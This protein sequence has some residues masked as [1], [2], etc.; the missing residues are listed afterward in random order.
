MKKLWLWLF[1]L[2]FIVAAATASDLKPPFDLPSAKVLP[3]GVRNFT[4]KGVLIDGG[5]KFN[6]AG[7]TERLSAPLNKDITFQTLLDSKDDPIDRGSITQP[8]KT[9]GATKDTKLGQTTGELDIAATANVPVFAYGITKKLTLAIAVPVVQSSI[10][11]DAGVVHT[12]PQL[13]NDF[14]TEIE[15]KGASDKAAEFDRKIKD[16]IGSKLEEYGY[17]ELKNENKTQLG[18]I[19]LVG[20]YNFIN[21]KRHV[22]TLQ[23]DITLPTGKEAD[24]NKVV[25]I[26]GGDG[27][28]DLGLTVIHD[29]NLGNYFTISSSLGYIAQL[30]DETAKRIPEVHDSSLSPDIDYN[31]DRNLGDHLNASLA[32]KF[33][34]HGFN[35][36]SGYSILYKE[37]D[38][39]SGN[40][41]SDERYGWLEQNTRQNMHAVQIST[42]YDTISLFKQKR[43]P[44]PL[45]LSIN[46]TRLVRGKNV[47][48]D[49]LTSLNFS[50]FF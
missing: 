34:Y 10:A 4:Y 36:G 20:K 38:R 13:V 44:V 23:G 21:S 39:Y 1:S 3:P 31:I 5:H 12:N 48:K 2:Q 43:F 35:L 27:Q 18:D 14:K 25:D 11:I 8:M 9:L 28:T 46:H 16:P 7:E 29:L 26:A 47:V 15:K 42:G 37:R 30:P 41:Y 33:Y 40:I 32:G 19:K 6:N 17:Q 24:V 49:P 50:M 22:L 45:S